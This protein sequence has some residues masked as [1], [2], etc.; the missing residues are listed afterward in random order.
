MKTSSMSGILLFGEIAQA[1]RQQIAH[2]L[3]PA[4]KIF[5]Q[6]DAGQHIAELLATTQIKIQKRLNY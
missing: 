3:Y 5:G 4:T 6:G 1:V 2:G